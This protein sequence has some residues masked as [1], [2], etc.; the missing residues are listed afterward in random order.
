VIAVDEFVKDDVARG[1]VGQIR[2]LDELAEVGAV[3]VDVPGHPDFAI[4]RQSDHLASPK[5]A[6]FVLIP[7]RVKRLDYL[8]RIEA[9]QGR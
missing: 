3:I 8:I 1:V 9:H 2:G 5:R 7:G 4:F 6:N